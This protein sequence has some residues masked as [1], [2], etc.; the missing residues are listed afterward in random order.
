ML[1]FSAICSYPMQNIQE[2]FL[3]MLLNCFNGQ[4]YLVEYFHQSRVPCKKEVSSDSVILKILFYRY[5][6]LMQ[7]TNREQIQR[8]G[9]DHC[10]LYMT[11]NLVPGSGVFL[12][13]NSSYLT[14]ERV[15]VIGSATIN[16]VQVVVAATNSGKLEQVTT[17][18]P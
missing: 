14:S 17:V 8:E 4:G 9:E 12:S 1:L 13:S 5:V 16:S 10:Y 3:N 11:L 15:T 2:R 18:L 6:F 7:N